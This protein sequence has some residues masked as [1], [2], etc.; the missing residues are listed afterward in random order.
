MRA[1]WWKE[2]LPTF[3]WECDAASFPAWDTPPPPFIPA[4]TAPSLQG[5]SVFLVIKAGRVL[6]CQVA[7]HHHVRSPVVQVQAPRWFTP[8]VTTDTHIHSWVMD[9]KPLRI[10]EMGAAEPSVSPA[11]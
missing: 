9:S 2:S 1:G 10:L 11:V 6:P 3:E 5:A 4:G 8:I 7:P